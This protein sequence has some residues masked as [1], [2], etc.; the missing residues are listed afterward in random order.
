MFI[1]FTDQNKVY[2][3]MQ[4]EEQL[5]RPKGFAFELASKSKQTNKIH[6]E[7]ILAHKDLRRQAQT[8]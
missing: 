3:S 8:I 5:V 2:A 4:Y 7:Q 1:P 6:T